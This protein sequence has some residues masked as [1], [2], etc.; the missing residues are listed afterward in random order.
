MKNL[1]KEI[2]K[3]V[4]DMVNDIFLHF[5]EKL[6]IEQG[7]IDFGDAF[8]L[9]ECQEKLTDLIEKVLLDELNSEETESE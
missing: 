1:N 8:D 3:K 6:G 2:Y 7:Y 9:D 5:Q 4:D